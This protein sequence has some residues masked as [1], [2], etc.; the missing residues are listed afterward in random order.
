MGLGDVVMPSLLVVSANV[1][2][3]NGGISYPVLGQCWGLCR[4]CDP[5]YPGD[6]RKPQAG[7]LPEFRAILGFAGVLLWEHQFCEERKR[8][9]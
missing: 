4:A 9:V 3:E 1:F 7:L 6:E 2:I 5:V 8:K